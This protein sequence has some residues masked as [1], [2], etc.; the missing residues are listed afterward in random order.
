MYIYYNNNYYQTIGVCHTIY[1]NIY[2]TIVNSNHYSADK[3]KSL[4]C[5][6]K[7]IDP[8]P[9]N[10]NNFKNETANGSAISQINY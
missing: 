7:G 6:Q 8:Y 4:I 3:G 9:M 2:F 10:E 5:L 1:K